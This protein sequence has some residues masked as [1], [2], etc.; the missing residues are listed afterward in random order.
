MAHVIFS[1][2]LIVYFESVFFDQVKGN[3]R[4]ILFHFYLRNLR[5]IQFSNYIFSYF[6]YF[7]KNF[8]QSLI[9][10]F[11]FKKCEKFGGQNTCSFEKI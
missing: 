6:S 9:F 2:N 8:I 4:T 5:L 11:N 1:I 10:N 3:R 7:I